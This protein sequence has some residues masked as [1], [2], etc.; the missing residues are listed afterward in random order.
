MVEGMNNV[1]LCGILKQ[2]AG[3]IIHRP[4]LRL[5]CNVDLVSLWKLHRGNTYCRQRLWS[6]Q[7][8]FEGRCRETNFP[9]S[10]LPDNGG[11]RGV[12]AVLNNSKSW[13]AKR[14]RLV[15]L[16]FHTVIFQEHM[17]SAFR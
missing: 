14:P 17:I 15:Y 10:H 11:E 2:T 8:V 16:L 1:M 7:G 4:T 6:F 12:I 9:E 3:Q 13:V 5:G